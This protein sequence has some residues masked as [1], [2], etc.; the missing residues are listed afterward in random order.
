MHSMALVHTPQITWCANT[1]PPVVPCL[2]SFN[3]HD[4][5]TTGTLSP[6]PSLYG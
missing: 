2:V 3:I 6:R 5:P 1:E 4:Y